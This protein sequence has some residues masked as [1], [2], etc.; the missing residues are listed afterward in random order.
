MYVNHRVTVVN[1]MLH[2]VVYAYFNDDWLR[3]I[4]CNALSIITQH[5]GH[6]TAQGHSRSP[7]LAHVLTESPVVSLGGTI[8]GDTL[9]GGDT[10]PK[11]RG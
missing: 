11:I 1:L 6:Y 5:N 2:V 4:Q 7:I 8:P 10:R 3:R 9:H